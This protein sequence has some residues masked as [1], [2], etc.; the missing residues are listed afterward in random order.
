MFGYPPF[1]RNAGKLDLLINTVWLVC[2]SKMRDATPLLFF[3]ERVG[4]GS[5]WADLLWGGLSQRQLSP[6]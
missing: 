4:K 6:E 5:Y 1:M 2:V 3:V